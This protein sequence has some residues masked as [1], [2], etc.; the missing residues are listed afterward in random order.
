MPFSRM[1]ASSGNGSAARTVIFMPSARTA[2]LRPMR[3]R[4]TMP[5][6]EPRI[7]LTGWVGH[8]PRR[9]AVSLLTMDLAV[10]ITRAMACSATAS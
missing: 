1:N 6:V 5:S 8:S 3:P 4:P 9:M 10:A 7:G 2:R